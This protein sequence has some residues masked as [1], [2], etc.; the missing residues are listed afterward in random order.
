MDLGVTGRLE[1]NM[2][3]YKC[4]ICGGDAYFDCRE[5]SD[6]NIE[7]AW[8][9]HTCQGK[10]EIMSK[11][12][13]GINA[14]E[15]NWVKYCEMLKNELFDRYSSGYQQGKFD[16]EMDFTYGGLSAYE[17][18]VRCEECVWFETTNTIGFGKCKN[19]NGIKTRCSKTFYC[20]YGERAVD[21]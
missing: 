16:C 15:Q 20:K 21:E 4:P 7:A 17:Q 19:P 3:K 6:E 1:K 8:W 10:Y 13:D 14:V 5:D 9:V 12:F 11:V 2:S 18:V